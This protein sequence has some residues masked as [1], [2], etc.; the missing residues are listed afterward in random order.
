M[1]EHLMTLVTEQIQ[2]ITVMSHQ[3][4]VLTDTTLSRNNSVQS[5]EVIHDKEWSD[6]DVNGC[7]IVTNK[8]RRKRRPMLPTE[9]P[10]APRSIPPAR[11]ISPVR[12][13]QPARSIS[14]VPPSRDAPSSKN[15][16]LAPDD[17]INRDHRNFLSQG[18]RKS[19]GEVVDRLNVL[20][21]SGTIH[22]AHQGKVREQFRGKLST[23]AHLLSV[24]GG[25][26]TQSISPHT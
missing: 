26:A 7:A 21:L 10:S 14:P 9:T 23:K 17:T 13:F 18:A 25:G 12:S 11:S 22:P 4:T 15:K 24:W 6:T 3:L 19:A 16:S 8:K 2:E 1:N 20:Y 5:G